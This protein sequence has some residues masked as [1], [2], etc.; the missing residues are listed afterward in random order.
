MVFDEGGEVGAH[1][2]VQEDG[3]RHRV[4]QQQ[5]VQRGRPPQRSRDAAR[6]PIRFN[7]PAI[8]RCNFTPTE[9]SVF[10]VCMPTDMHKKLGD[11]GAHRARSAC[12]VLQSGSSPCAIASA[13]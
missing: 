3:T 7:Y 13:E 10:A 8:M 9:K 5:N 12:V 4:E 2:P 6:Q 11:L 1:E